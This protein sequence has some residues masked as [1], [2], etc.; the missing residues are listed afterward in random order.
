[1]VTPAGP[2]VAGDV[3]L[4]QLPQFLEALTPLSKLTLT[5]GAEIDKL[6]IAIDRAGGNAAEPL[7]T[8]PVPGDVDIDVYFRR[9]MLAYAWGRDA[10]FARFT[11]KRGTL[12]FVNPVIGVMLNP[13]AAVPPFLAANPP[14]WIAPPN[15][16]GDLFADEIGISVNIPGLAFFDLTFERPL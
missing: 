13:L 5:L 1:H 14:Y 3:R 12:L 2:A 4:V 8:V 7:L 6:F 9:F 10:F 11:V 16:M 15:M